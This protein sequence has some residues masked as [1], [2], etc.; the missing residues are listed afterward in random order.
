MGIERQIYH[1]SEK[2]PVLISKLKRHRFGQTLEENNTHL[3]K[4]SF[5]NILSKLLKQFPY[6]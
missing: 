3:G 5:F 4:N 1:Y 2:N 6:C